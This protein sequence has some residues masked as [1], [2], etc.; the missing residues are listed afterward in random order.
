VHWQTHG[1]LSETVWAD[2]RAESKAWRNNIAHLVDTYSEEEAK[3]LLAVIPVFLRDLA[4]KM[5]EKGKLY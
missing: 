1:E 4:T 2:L 3:N 5:N